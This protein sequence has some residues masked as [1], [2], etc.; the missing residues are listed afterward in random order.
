MAVFLSYSRRD[1][2]VVTVLARGFHAAHREV[3]FDHDL[4]GGEV[5]WDTILRN[6]RACSVFVL[7]VSDD[8][9][10]S[11]ACTAELEY[12]EQLGRPIL[13]VE[14]GRVT[15]VR[16]YVLADLQSVYFD[17][18]D[19]ATGF[20]VLAA[21]DHAA[22]RAGPLPD[23]LPPEPPTPFAY[24]QAVRRS[25]E[26]GGLS[27]SQQL[28]AVDQLRR[29]LSDET[30]VSVRDEIVA[31]LASM[32]DKPWLSRG[33]GF[34]VRAVLIAHR[35][36]EAEVAGDPTPGPAEPEEPT[37]GRGAFTGGGLDPSTA[38]LERIDSVH[39]QMQAGK[40]WREAAS[41][42]PSPPAE[43]GQGPTGPVRYL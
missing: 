2:D 6:I 26:R 14:V 27:H 24:L 30:E 8:S 3:W 35:T 29:A 4:D 36:I 11:R 19:A 25:I 43:T 20:S 34:E 1:E 7:A 32:Q 16:S 42:A 28:T 18:D 17:P 40:F 22:E 13:P 39:R 5:W 23:P 31:I 21:A 9:L 10:A 37:T 41:S 12:A 15:A 38:F 33:A